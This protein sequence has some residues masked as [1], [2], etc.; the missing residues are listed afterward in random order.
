MIFLLLLLLLQTPQALPASKGIQFLRLK[1]DPAASQAGFDGTTTLESFTARSS[2]VGGEVHLHAGV[3]GS[4]VGGKV[5]LKVET[6]DSGN[7]GRD[8]DMFSKLEPKEYPRITFFLDHL[9]GRLDDWQGELSMRGRFLIHGVSRMRTFPIQV[10]QEFDGG[11]RVRGEV[12]F[13]ITDHGMV[14]P[15]LAV[16][17][18]DDEVR[19]WFDAVFRTVQ[20]PLVDCQFRPLHVEETLKATGKDP[21]TAQH[22]ESLWT[23]KNSLLW[24]RAAE[25]FWFLQTGDRFQ[26]LKLGPLQADNGAIPC[27]SAFSKAA[28]QA[29]ALRAKLSAMPEARRKTMEGRIGPSLARLEKASALAPAA[30]PVKIVHD[31]T[32]TSL[33]LGDTDWVVFEGLKGEEAFPAMLDGLDGLPQAIH[34]TLASLRGIP[35]EV[36]VRTVSAGGVRELLIKPGA[37]KASQLPEWAFATDWWK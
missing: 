6:L 27:D 2:G 8:E 5:W 13:N 34:K 37:P 9:D 20:A 22:F 26:R 36:F 32:K 29:S 18:T 7:A 17:K 25:S 30:G 3:F 23:T 16:I 4:T 19:V 33:R 14:P 24:E 21:V 15:V 10:T 11:V 28:R 12:R 1:L 31:G 35:D